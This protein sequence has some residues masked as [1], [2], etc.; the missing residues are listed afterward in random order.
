MHWMT[1]IFGAAIVVSLYV[2]MLERVILYVMCIVTTLAHWH[3]G[4]KVVGFFF[5]CPANTAQSIII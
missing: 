3:Y 1:P 4:V 5:C 2:P